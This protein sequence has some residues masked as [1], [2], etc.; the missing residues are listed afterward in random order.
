MPNFAI[1]P[2]SLHRLRHRLEALAP[3]AAAEILQDAGF[4]TGGALAERWRNRVAERTGL[5]DA[6]LLDARWFGPLL[7]ELCVQLG[8]GSL[9]VVPLG[10]VAV[11]LEAGAWAE[12]EPGASRHPGCHFSS[13][14]LAAFL[15]AQAGTAIGVLEVECRSKG[16]EA[17]R[18]I[19]GAAETLG[20]VYD[21]LSAGGDWRDA[22]PAEG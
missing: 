3:G 22:L 18:F 16:D 19:A 1:T 11:L 7:D 15:T 12:A 2:A 14:V 5:L 4:L 9:T 8:W 13:G 21:L 6:G 10:D 17:C 20:A